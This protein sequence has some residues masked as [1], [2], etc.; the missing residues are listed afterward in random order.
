[1]LKKRLFPSFGLAA[2]AAAQNLLMATAL[3][4]CS[5]LAFWQITTAMLLSLLLT[6]WML[7]ISTP[8][9]E[10]AAE[11]D[12]PGITSPPASL[13]KQALVLTLH[14]T[15]KSDD[16]LRLEALRY[17]AEAMK[18]V[19]A[20]LDGALRR[21]AC[22]DL[23]IRL[24]D[25]FPE[26]FEG[27]RTDFNQSVMRI[28]DTLQA[29]TSTASAL[30]GSGA[31]LQVQVD[32]AKISFAEHSAA[33]AKATAETGSLLES[34]RQRDE[35][36]RHLSTVSYNALLDLRKSQDVFSVPLT[37]MRSVSA[38]TTEMAPVAD[39]IVQLA[40]EANM[41]AMNLNI[42]ASHREGN[43]PA[44]DGLAEEIR[45]LAEETA[46]AAKQ[47][48]VLGRRAAQVAATGEQQANRVSGE[49]AAI[50]IYVEAL[51]QK[52]EKLST[53]TI[54]QRQDADSLRSAVMTLAKSSRDHA[55]QVEQLSRKADDMTRGV[56]ALDRQA[57]RYIPVTI[58][59]PDSVFRPQ[60]TD[61][62]IRPPHLR[63]VTP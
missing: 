31:E 11:P 53:S 34:T 39:R 49:M 62:P 17:E 55:V 41:A 57:G 21:L 15:L 13:P 46:E 54:E 20:T 61:K 14:E 48:A 51:H 45:R 59:Q 60:P 25:E 22:G 38:T 24:A 42:Q 26:T 44:M 58:I 7:S 27:L 8:P 19:L 16:D 43:A 36:I 6:G 35:E 52:T 4:L 10:Q 12:N 37:A 33:I 5:S 30:H 32:A 63:L 9:T 28:E 3:L 2:L 40:L 29:V 18:A 23:T 50:G 1:M 56:M 47:V